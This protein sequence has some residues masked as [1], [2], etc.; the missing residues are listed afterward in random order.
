[1]LIARWRRFS[2]ERSKKGSGLAG[3]CL[4]YSHGL[5]TPREKWAEKLGQAQRSISVN[6]SI[7]PV[8]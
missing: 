1:M 8:A 5:L 2:E 4:F 7:H 3:T 6:G